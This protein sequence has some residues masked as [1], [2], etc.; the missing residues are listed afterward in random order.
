MLEYTKYVG[1]DTHKKTIAV[2]IADHTG[3]LGYY[4][5]IENTP[6]AIEKLIKQLSPDGEVINFCYEAGPCGYGLYR[7]ITRLT[8]ISYPSVA[9]VR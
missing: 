5:S 4:G 2:A 6:S 3:D 8:T 1:L 7:N 9:R